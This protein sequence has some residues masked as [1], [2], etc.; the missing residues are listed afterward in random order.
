MVNDELT[1]Q[2]REKYSKMWELDSYRERSPGLRFL[3]N[4]LGLVNIPEGCSVVDLGAGTGRVS[5]ELS[6]RGYQVTAVDIAPNA[7]R[8]FD[9]PVLESCL[10][11][12]PQFEER[13]EFGY[14]A[15]VMEHIPR[16]RVDATLACISR[17]CELVYFQIA[18]F[19]CREGDRIGEELHLTVEDADWWTER[20][21]R[22]FAE[23]YIEKQP[24]H[25]VALCVSR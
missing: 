22:Q 3:E 21:G 6:R 8:E 14:C 1:N 19:H 20:L 16:E 5:A 9:G 15:D 24:K 11:E 17:S 13:F 12:L 10:W 7:V 23:V 18:N 2:E 4:A 25:T